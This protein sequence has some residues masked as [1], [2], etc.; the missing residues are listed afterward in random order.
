MAVPL[1]LEPRGGLVPYDPTE[2]Q[3]HTGATRTL[4]L[5]DAVLPVC[6]GIAFHQKQAPG[7]QPKPYG[8]YRPISFM[9]QNEGTFFAKADGRYYGAIAQLLFIIA[10]ET[11]AIAVI[12]IIVQQDTVKI[13]VNGMLDPFPDDL[14]WLDPGQRLQR[15]SRILIA[16]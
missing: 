13:A 12:A 16:S 14:Q 1:L 7:F 11:H 8:L 3:V 2:C 15:H 10:M 6:L 5:F 9:F 4:F